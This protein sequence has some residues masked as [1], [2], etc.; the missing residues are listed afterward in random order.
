MKRQHSLNLFVLTTAL[1]GALT[2]ACAPQE[3]ED[4]SESQES[5]AKK[6][7][8]PDGGITSAKTV[9]ELTK[10]AWTSKAT[11]AGGY[12]FNSNPIGLGDKKEYDLRTGS[13]PMTASFGLVEQRGGWAFNDTLSIAVGTTEKRKP[14]GV[15][16]HFAEPLSDRSTDWVFDGTMSGQAWFAKPGAHTISTRYELNPFGANVTDGD[17]TEIVRPITHVDIKLDAYDPLYPGTEAAYTITEGRPVALRKSD[18]T[19]SFADYIVAH[20]DRFPIEV[21]RGGIKFGTIPTVAGGTIPVVFN[22]L[23]IDDV[24]VTINGRTTTQKGTSTIYVGATA[25]GSALYSVPTHTG[26]D[27]PNGTYTV[28]STTSTTFGNV[29]H[30]ETISFP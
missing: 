21:Q 7:I 8:R 22:R 1:T 4:E 11:F 16:V 5:E 12:Y 17:L 3:E 18:G 15:C 26:V 30:T 28:V 25:A 23:E 10:P 13:A 29:T 24:E 2:F 14:A 27:L 9:F 20:S 19:P 6:K